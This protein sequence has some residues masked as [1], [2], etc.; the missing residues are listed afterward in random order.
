MIL[1]G[2]DLV[3]GCGACA[4]AGCR[5]SSGRDPDALHPRRRGALTL[6]QFGAE[7][8]RLGRA[9]AALD[10][11]QRAGRR[12][13]ARNVRI[14]LCCDCEILL[15]LAGVALTTVRPSCDQGRFRP[16]RGRCGEDRGIDRDFRGREPGRD[17]AGFGRATAEAGPFL[18]D[19]VRGRG[20][21]RV[22]RT[23]PMPRPGSRCCPMRQGGDRRGGCDRQGARPGGGR[24]RAR[25]A[26]GQTL[27]SFFWPAQNAELLEACKDEGR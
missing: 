6:A 21:G 19:P 17:D 5:S 26:T 9:R 7:F 11:A 4:S 14:E 18:P 12:T 22:S 24:G 1:A 2:R 27:I 15:R 16:R 13:A 25:C 3:V 20:E 23:P 8:D 10:L